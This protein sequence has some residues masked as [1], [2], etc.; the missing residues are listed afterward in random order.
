[1]YYI[2]YVLYNYC[3]TYAL[4]AVLNRFYA[5]VIV[6]GAQYSVD[7]ILLKLTV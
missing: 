4:S 7:L 3:L 2:I 1:M 6:Y 5:I